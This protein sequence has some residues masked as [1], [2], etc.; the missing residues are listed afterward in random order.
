MCKRFLSLFLLLPVLFTAVSGWSQDGAGKAPPAKKSGVSGKAAASKAPTGQKTSKAS[1]NP[2]TTKA[3]TGQKTSTSQKS[4]TASKR[5]APAKS[6]PKAAA[7]QRVNSARMKRMTRAFV[8]SATLKPMAR[9]LIEARTLTAY[10]G[11]EQ[12]AR[13]HAGTDAGGMAWLTIGY[14]H[15]L[16]REYAKAIAPLEKARPYAGELAD[17]AR[18]F[19]ALAYGGSGQSNQV[20]ATLKN[21]SKE[22]ADSIFLNDARAVY[23]EALVASG[24]ASEAV[25]FLEANRAPTRADAELALGHAYLNSGNPAKGMEI[26]RH[27]Y[28]TM[29]LSTEAAQAGAELIAKGSNP[30][31]SYSDL[32]MHA[33]LLAQGNRWAD[34]TREYRQ[35]LNMAPP[36]ERG[37]IEIGLGNALRHGDTGRMREGRDLLQNAQAT[38]EANAQRLY[39]LAE[40]ARTEGNEGDLLNYLSQFR[41][42]APT[43]AW[44]QPALI[45]A[46]NMYMLKKDYDHA[47][48][49]YREAHERFPNSSRASYA[50][51]KAAW[52]TYRQGRTEEAKKEFTQ[53]V[54][55]YPASLETAAAVYWR[56]RIAEGENDLPLARAWYAKVAERYRNYYYGHLAT[57]R[58]AK[59]GVSPTARDPLLDTIAPLAPLSAG[60][61]LTSIPAEALRVEKSKLLEN[62]GMTDFA[63]KE[64][65]ASDGGKGANW[66]TLEIARIYN[67]G[68]QVHRALRFMKSAVPSYFAIDISVLPRP[69]WDYLFPRPYWTEIRRFA[70]ENQLDPY[71]VAALIRQESEFNPG[72]VS[73]ANAFGLMQLL[74]VTGKKT[75]KELHLRS[76]R[77]ETLLVPNINLQL[78]T[79]YFREMVDHYNGQVE[80]AL[81]AY[82]A[83]P[84]RVEDWLSVGT[85]RDVPEFVES[86]PF[87]ETREYVQSI[88]RNARIYRRL[89]PQ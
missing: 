16:D 52:L 27:L 36:A 47:I 28:L 25:S 44:F 34:A 73:R 88:M 86:I 60:A 68:G 17:Y 70:M 49:Y 63:I 21:F 46:G 71:L 66:A 78:G 38:G 8:A 26:L 74:P 56:G 89:Y 3:S 31:G 30:T 54:R 33:S 41:Q 14:A 42:S 83:G 62:A 65:Q 18:Y 82:N 23:G 7:R 64:L 4:A 13:Q 77:T 75:A 59:I 43:S 1:T 48:D 19:E 85:Y 37:E 51:W 39:N 35:L 5:A 87:T 58:L 84:H 67:D 40:I 20:V 9:Q 79:R 53:H 45:S 57:E 69:Y 6:A 29:P 50:H 32:K 81:A 11:V 55:S 72:A 76:F 10:A 80:Y 61:G 22:C 12:Y 15:I 24:R 2:T